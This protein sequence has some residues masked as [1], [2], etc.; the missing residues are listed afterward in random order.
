[1]QITS[2]KDMYI[3]ELQKPASM[4]RH[5]EQTGTQMDRLEQVLRN[6][7]SSP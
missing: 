4:G 2:F 3:A 5:R 1:M 7:G 6:H